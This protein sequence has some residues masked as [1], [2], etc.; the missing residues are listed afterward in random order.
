[1]ARDLAFFSELGTYVCSLDQDQDGYFWRTSQRS[2]F[3]GWE[4]Y[5]ERLPTVGMIVSGV[6]YQQQMLE[7]DIVG[8]D[9][10]QSV[11][12]SSPTSP[13][14]WPT[15]RA[16]EKDQG[17][18]ANG[19]AEG[20]SSW[21]SQGRG[22]TLT[23]AVKQYARS[24]E[25]LWP[26]PRASKIS[27]DSIGRFLRA[28]SEGKVSTPPLE[29]AVRMW[30]TICAA[31]YRGSGPLGSKSHYHR[32]ERGYL[33]ATVQESVQASGKLNPD[34]VELLMGYNVGF[35]LPEGEE[36]HS[37]V[38]AS[39]WADGSWEDGVPRLSSANIYRAKRLKALGN[40][41]VPQCVE[42][43]FFNIGKGLKEVSG[44]KD[45]K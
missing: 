27:G 24:S 32:L 23:T 28:K 16:S 2:L 25:K 41:V 26:T 4:R 8:T 10:G 34:W 7:L 11:I 37:M 38:D 45:N 44:A 12:P 40:S 18:K 30:P 13:G 5:S 35:S 29:T 43:L 31:Q 6:V 1:M 22:A 33:D 17:S 19:M 39:T 14:S 15:P 20:L 21:K 9:G 42:A 36:D 3:G